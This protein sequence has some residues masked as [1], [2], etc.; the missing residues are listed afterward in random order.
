MIRFETIEKEIIDYLRREN[1]Y[2]PVVL[3]DLGG[4]TTTILAGIRDFG[5]G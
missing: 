1:K 4:P 3:P 5:G 2:K